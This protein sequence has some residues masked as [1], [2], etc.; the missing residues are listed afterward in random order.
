MRLRQIKIAGFKSFADPTVIDIRDP[1][2]G[3]VGPNGCGK[4]NII[5]AVRWVLGEGRVSELRGGAMSE[6]IFTGSARR[7]PLGRASV[8]LLLDNSDHAVKGPWGQYA[9]LSIRRVVT[10]EGVSAYYINHQQVRKRDVQEIFLGTGLGSRSYAIVSQG[11]IERFTSARPEEIRVYLEEAAGVSLYKE[12]RRETESHLRQTQENLE[13]AADLQSVR[14]EEIEKLRAEAATAARWQELDRKKTESEALWYF[15]MSENA[16]READQAREAITRIENDIAM[17]RAAVEECEAAQEGLE[18]EVKK[19][20]A[21]HERISGEFREAE[22]ELARLEGEMSRIVERRRTAERDRTQAAE[23]I[24]AKEKLISE[25]TLRREESSEK[26]AEL[27]AL[28]EEFEEMNETRAEALDAAEEAE[29]TTRAAAETAGG[30]LARARTAQQVE[31]V[32]LSRERERVGELDR[33]LSRIT[34]DERGSEKPDPEKVEA[35]AEALVEAGEAE[36]EA[37]AKREEALERA[38]TARE[39][40]AQA[41]EKYFA[42]LSE[43]KSLSAKLSTL[44][45]VQRS[46]EKSDALSKWLEETGIAGLP[47]LIDSIEVPDELLTALEAV[48]EHRMQALLLRDLRAAGDLAR[49]RPP[50]RLSFAA[51]EPEGAAAPALVWEI[52]GRPVIRLSEHVTTK[53]PAARAAIDAWASCAGLAPDLATALRAR[54]TLPEGHCFVTPQGDVVTRSSL[55]FWAAE[56]PRLALLSR[57]QEIRELSARVEALDI[58]VGQADDRRN[59]AAREETDSRRAAEL[60]QTAVAEAARRTAA[61]KLAE[62]EAR[63]TLEEALRRE[64]D[65]KRSREELERE[66]A[67]VSARVDEM[68]ETMDGLAEALE[69]AETAAG[70]AA[71][72]YARAQDRLANERREQT[73]L[74]H[75]TAMKRLEIQQAREGAQLDERRIEEA[76]ADVEREKTRLAEA[77]KLLAEEDQGTVESGAKALL[78]KSAGLERAAADAQGRLAETRRKADENRKLAK[79]LTEGILPLTEQLGTLRVT[80]EQKSGLLSQ[81]NDRMEE[82]GADWQT[83]SVIAQERKVKAPAV[84]SEVTRLMNEIAALGPVNHAALSHLE[85]A[86]EAMRLAEAQINDLKQAVETLEAAIRKIDSETRSRMRETFEKVNTNFAETFRGLFGGGVASLT[87]VGDEILTAGVEVRAQPPGKR[88]QSLTLL[89]GGEK[90]LTATA[91]IFAMFRLN[92]APFCL[93]DEVD[94]PLDEANQGRLARLCLGMSE[95]T[96]FIIITH[97]RVTM[98]YASSLIGVTM[99]EPGVSRVVSVDIEEAVRQSSETVATAGA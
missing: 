31:E 64:A 70:E 73:E 50:A 28:L 46:A 95:A 66:R 12:R 42:L 38:E 13:R 35:L 97:H 41:N 45:E 26:I 93:L 62:R 78:E 20:D 77:E 32:K 51:P 54:T 22:K 90:A 30:A 43:Q 69:S 71:A 74:I 25:M 18:N 49:S 21:E 3:I 40:A 17:K 82:L 2:I 60:A 79:T 59:A 29:R 33:R 34:E 19:A 4:S 47:E 72:A 39:A 37:A 57:A 65:L 88:N 10:T 85:A 83:L 48:L 27:E 52:E 6:L 86:E 98:E 76:K 61:A 8:E 11:M 96:Q 14:A 87:L 55:T 68:L 94:A 81:F 63:R 7:A 67:E 99:K 1:L 5:D 84:K 23:T 89:S 44:E 16:R 80:A 15:L 24:A 91:L 56:D 36:E 58:E 9:E 53:H 75:R 92:P